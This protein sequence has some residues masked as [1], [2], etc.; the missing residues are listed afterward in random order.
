MPLAAQV[1]GHAD[2][3]AVLDLCLPRR[4]PSQRR[5]GQRNDNT[6]NNAVVNAT[7]GG[8]KRE[9]RESGG[10]MTHFSSKGRRDRPVPYQQPWLGVSFNVSV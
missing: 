2:E 9:S 6:D 4:A 1:H 5:A 8:N 3:E 7:R 10:F